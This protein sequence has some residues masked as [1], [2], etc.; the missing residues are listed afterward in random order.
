MNRTLILLFLFPFFPFLG[1]GQVLI[2]INGGFNFSTPLGNSNTNPHHDVDLS[3]NKNGVLVSV[4]V[5]NRIPNKIVNI[6]GA[7]EYYN[8]VLT[9]NQQIGGGGGGTNYHYDFTLHFLN[10]MVKPEFVFGSKWRFIINSGA[11]LG[12]LLHGNTTG[13]WQT[14]GFPPV[15]NGVIN[16]NTN[17]YFNNLNFGFLGGIGTECPITDRIIINLEANYTFGITNLAKSSLT[18]GVFNLL[19]AQLS[20][21]LAYKFNWVKKT[22]K[23]KKKID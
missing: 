7:A 16:E 23:E 8:T 4:F 6:G 19:N 21:G 1:Y 5:K 11:F 18:K 15:T 2:G 20:V 9:G 13:V 3:I 22:G 10:I 17:H 14:Y 12:I